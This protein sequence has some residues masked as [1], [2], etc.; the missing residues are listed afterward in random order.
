MCRHTHAGVSPQKFEIPRAIGSLY[1]LCQ[2]ILDNKQ[3]TVMTTEEVAVDLRKPP[4]LSRHSQNLPECYPG[5]ILSGS[6]I[7]IEEPTV[8]LSRYILPL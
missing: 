6:I 4:H 5:Y 8:E 7:K 2:S 3:S 1:P